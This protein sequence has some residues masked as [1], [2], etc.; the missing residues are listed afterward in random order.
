MLVIAAILRDNDRILLARRHAAVDGGEWE[1][2]GGKLERGETAEQ[3]IVRE[4]REEF[5]IVIQAGTFF[6]ETTIPGTSM[7]LQAYFAQ[8]LD[9]RELSLTAH[10]EYAWVTVPELTNYNLL[11]ADQPIAEKLQRPVKL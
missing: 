3:C 8:R 7:T 2:P 10:R 6:A 5:G 4:I 1:F 11:P 9:T